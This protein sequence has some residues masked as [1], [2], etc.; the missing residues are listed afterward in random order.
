MHLYRR[1]PEADAYSLDGG[2]V[3]TPY[4]YLAREKRFSTAELMAMYWFACA[5]GHHPRQAKILYR[6]ATLPHHDESDE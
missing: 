6:F 5:M 3:Y 1:H 4:A 2:N